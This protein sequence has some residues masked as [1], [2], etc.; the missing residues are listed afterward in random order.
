[1]ESVDINK[2]LVYTIWPRDAQ[3]AIDKGEGGQ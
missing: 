1:V 2:E 3:D